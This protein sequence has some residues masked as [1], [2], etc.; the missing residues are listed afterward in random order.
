MQFSELEQKV[1]NRADRLI[2]DI[3][4]G[5]VG[6]ALRI[7]EDHIEEDIMENNAYQ[8]REQ[9]YF[10]N[11]GDFL[12]DSAIKAI[13]NIN[14]P[15][16][17]LKLERFAALLSAVCQ[18]YLF[19]GMNKVLFKGCILPGNIFKEHMTFDLDKLISHYVDR[20]ETVS[21]HYIKDIDFLEN[22]FQVLDYLE[23]YF[24]SSISGRVNSEIEPAWYFNIVFVPN[25]GFVGHYV[26]Y[27]NLL[28]K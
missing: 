6:G 27:N 28:E 9:V 22:L 12:L 5:G 7:L 25:K 3:Q 21:N 8:V 17:G 15:E 24:S 4:Q 13:A 23:R 11:T 1:L 10:G 20:E 16:D 19:S 2:G 26:F 18:E 14:V